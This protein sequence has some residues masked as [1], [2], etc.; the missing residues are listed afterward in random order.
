AISSS[1]YARSDGAWAIRAAFARTLPGSS[2]L[3]QS[4]PDQCTISRRY[5]LLVLPLVIAITLRSV[6]YSPHG[7]GVAAAS[8]SR[9]SASLRSLAIDHLS[10]ESMSVVIRAPTVAW[11]ASGVGRRGADSRD[12]TTRR[13][14]PQS[15]ASPLPGDLRRPP[16]AAC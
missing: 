14:P 3:L 11:S 9:I 2:M 4:K 1:R 7:P 8:R 6:A 16:P 10:V 12:A 13:P 15:A 5:P